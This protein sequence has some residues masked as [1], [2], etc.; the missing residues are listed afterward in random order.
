MDPDLVHALEQY[1]KFTRAA[2]GDLSASLGAFDVL[3]GNFALSDSAR[4]EAL[5]AVLIRLGAALGAIAR[6]TSLRALAPTEGGDPE[7]VSAFEGALS[8]LSQLAIGA[9]GRLDPGRVPIAPPG[10]RRPLTVAVARVLSE[11]EPSLA[12][13]VIAASLDALLAGVPAAIGALASAVVWRMV[14]LPKEGRRPDSKSM[15]VAEALPA[16]LSPRRAIGGFHV[17][18]SLSSGAVGSVF[19]ATR[20]EDRGDESAERFALKV[21]EYSAT[22]ARS[23]SEAEFLKLFREEAS[24]LMALPH[25]PNLARFVTFDAGCK[26]KPIL[27]ME[28]VE[29]TTLESLL[30]ARG[31]SMARALRIVEDVLS[32]LQ[33][34]HAVGVG[35]LDLKPSN[36]VL[37]GGEEAV[38]VDFGLS[39]KHIRPGCATGPYGAPEVWGAF[40]ERADLSPLK[41]D[42][43]SSA[44]VAFEALTGRVLFEAE[45]EMAQIAAHLAHD[46]FPAPLRALAGRPGMS[47]LAELFFS[48][49]RRDP[50]DRPTVAAVNGEFSR[51]TPTLGRKSW[52][53]EVK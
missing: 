9:R 29:G 21:P 41:A 48:M 15:L 26:P 4:S 45:S 53:L 13:H 37:R 42:V 35:H 18:R 46:G 11:A 22:A 27:V 43:Y 12:E 3:T 49:L 47:G 10:R 40:G 19:V 16:W 8:A 25:H 52:P 33:A 28:L 39:G 6:A 38:L 20:L 32:G 24:A 31:L 1:A 5:R 50:R 34:M 36:A 7:T 51:L 2:A 44:C 17:V 14:E 23:L 30:Q